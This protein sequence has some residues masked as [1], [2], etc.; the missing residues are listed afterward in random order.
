MLEKVK[1]LI[2]RPTGYEIVF[3]H[4]KGYH[5]KPYVEC[6][7]KRPFVG[8]LAV[9][10]GDYSEEE[11]LDECLRLLDYVE[12]LE[13]KYGHIKKPTEKF[14]AIIAK[15]GDIETIICFGELLWYTGYKKEGELAITNIS[16]Q[17]NYGYTICDSFNKFDDSLKLHNTSD[18]AMLYGRYGESFN[19]EFAMPLIE[20]EKLCM[21]DDIRLMSGTA[22]C[23]V[24]KDGEIIRY[25]T[26]LMA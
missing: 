3:H 19:Q 12:E 23:A 17:D 11:A 18:V 22:G 13:N 2:E 1:E 7:I 25:K 9:K 24:V 4:L 8:H 5:P 10:R 16:K 21:W 26:I 20:G 6:I 14:S 15:E